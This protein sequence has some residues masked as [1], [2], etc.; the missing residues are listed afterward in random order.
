MK[1]KSMFEVRKTRRGWTVKIAGERSGFSGL[2]GTAS[3]EQAGYKYGDDPFGQNQRGT[4][5]IDSL[6]QACGFDSIIKKANPKLIKRGS[7]S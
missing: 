1:G 5:M 2:I 4:I 3:I 7:K 6:I